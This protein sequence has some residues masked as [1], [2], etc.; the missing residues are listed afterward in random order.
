MVTARSPLA[1][2]A[3]RM[4]SSWLSGSM[5]MYPEGLGPAVAYFV[6]GSRSVSGGGLSWERAFL[7]I[8]EAMDAI[9]A[10]G[11]LRG[12]SVVYVGTCPP[13]DIFYQ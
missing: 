7:T 5:V 8:T 12:R 13:T 4:Y 3:G 9:T 11:A 2:T 6:D 1:R 10:R